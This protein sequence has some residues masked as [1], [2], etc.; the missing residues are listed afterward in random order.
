MNLVKTTAAASAAAMILAASPAAAAVTLEF[1][2][3][4][5]STENTGAS[6]SAIFTFTDVGSDVR[7]DL[8][9][10]NT[11]DG[12]L[13]LGATQATLVGLAFDLP[14]FTAISY[15]S[16]STAFSQLWTEVSLPPYGTFSV[17]IS[18]PRNSFAGGNPQSGLTALNTL[19]T[20]SFTAD[21]TLSAAAFEAAFLAGH[22]ASGL[23]DAAARF[24]QVNAG[25]G[26]DKV[27]GGTAV[28]EPSTGALMLL[29][30]G[31]AGALIRRRRY[32][33][34]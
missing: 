24:Q 19:S 21:T 17:G 20:V 7:I 27:K 12:S 9:L 34:A 13:G 4:Y 8:S 11:T 30:F 5:G 31:G 2:P 16:N 1:K 26:S 14:T 22:S 15:N 32:A 28:P 29:G 3:V 6:A 33:A 23:M 10:S 25:G 18:P